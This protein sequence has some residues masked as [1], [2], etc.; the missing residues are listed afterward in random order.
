MIDDILGNLIIQYPYA[1]AIAML[2]LCI[3]GVVVKPNLIKKILALGLILDSVNL[4]VILVGYRRVAEAIPPIYPSP[5]QVQ[6]VVQTAVDPLP[7]CLVLTAIVIDTCVTA[8][9]LGLIV[10]IYRSYGSIESHKVREL[11]E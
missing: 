3:Y 10:M 6:L 11:K 1:F 4:Y 8:L 7:Q 5:E 2:V 9:A